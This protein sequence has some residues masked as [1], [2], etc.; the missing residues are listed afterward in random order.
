[1]KT[2]TLKRIS[3]ISVAIVIALVLSLVAVAF[4]KDAQ[5]QAQAAAGD[6]LYMAEYKGDNGTTSASLDLSAMA[7]KYGVSSD[8]IY[9]INNG[10]ELYNFLTGNVAISKKK[11]G[12]LTQDVGIAYNP[13]STIE[14]YYTVNVSSSDAIFEKGRI[15]DGNGHTINIYGGAGIS[16]SSTEVRDTDEPRLSNRNGAGRYDNFDIWYEYT[17][18][19]VA[20]N[21]GTLKDF[22]VNY[23]S[24]HTIISATWGETGTKEG[25]LGMATSN[26]ILSA[27]EGLFSAGIITGL[28]GYNGVID[29]IKVNV[30]N[31]FTVIK[32]EAGVAS[33]QKKTGQFQENSAYA[34]AIAGRIEDNSIIN[35]C[36]VDLAEGTGI[37]A[38]A[39]GKAT[40]FALTD[41]HNSMAIAGGIVGNIDAGTAKITYCS[42]SG[43]G[44]V[45]AFANRAA[46]DEKFRAYA[47]GVAG[48]CIKIANETTIS[49]CNSGTKVQQGQIKGIISS[50]RGTRFSNF[51][52]KPQE[53]MGSLFDAVGTDDEIE[54]LAIL[55]NLDAL[56]E[57]NTS[58]FAVQPK[59]TDGKLVLD[60]SGNIRNWLEINPITDGGAMTVMFD[61]DNPTYDI[62]VHIVADGH[63]EF[64]ASGAMDDFDMNSSKSR[65]QQYKMR[66]GEGGGFIWSAQFTDL[67]G[68]TSSHIDVFRDEPIYAEIYLISSKNNGKYNYEFGR[69]GSVQYVDTNGTNGNLI[70]EYH[71]VSD[72]LN[73][74]SVTMTNYDAF[75]KSVFNNPALWKITRSNKEVALSQT[76]M[77]GTYTM[78][79]ETF[80]GERAYAYYSEAERMLAWQP[81]SNY[82]FT[83][84]QGK[85]NFG[86]GTTTTDGWQD[87]VTFELAMDS[88]S[89]FDSIAFQ[90][91]G[92][93]PSGPVSADEVEY[94]REDNS[95]SASFIIKAG[96]GKNGTSY[97]FY[98]Y[99]RDTVANEDVVVAVSDSRIV[100]IDTEAPEVSEIEYYMLEDGV[101]RLLTDDDLEYIAEHWTKNQVLA[102]F[103]VIEN[104][105]SGIAVAATES[106]IQDEVLNSNGDRNVVVTIND[107]DLKE[108]K[109]VDA[110]GNET[111]VPLQINVDRVEGKLKFK[112][113]S[114]RTDGSFNYSTKN[115]MVTYTATFGKSDWRLYYSYQRNEQGGD[116]WIPCEDLLNESAVSGNDSVLTINWNMGDIYTGIG[117]D[118]KIKMINETGLYEDEVFP[119]NAEG[120]R[121]ENDAIGKYVIWL[122]LASIY[123]DTNLN[124]VFTYE[125]GEKKTVEDILLN[126]EERAEYFDKQYDGTDEYK[127]EYKFYADF[128]ELNNEDGF[129]SDDYLGVIYSPAGMSRPLIVL[130][131]NGI[132][133]VEVK[134]TSSAVG[135]TKVSFRVVLT[136]VDGYN[137]IVYFTDLSEID[138]FEDVEVEEDTY[139]ETCE[140]D[141]KINKVTITIELGEQE[142]FNSQKIY[143][144]GDE[145]PT[146]I[147]VY[148]EATDEYVPVKIDT[149]ASSTATI[150]Q[151][152][153]KGIAPNGYENIEYI[154]NSTNIEIKQRPVA[155]DLIF[156]NSDVVGNIP[157]GVTAGNSH[158][159]TG[160]YVDV[161]GETQKA[162]IEYVL[163]ERPVAT[164]SAV[165]LYTINITLPDNNYAVSG[166]TSFKFNIARGQLDIT[167]GVRVKDYTEGQLQYDLIIPEGSKDLYEESDLSIKYYEYL[168]GAT[169]NAAE[170]RVIGKPSD[171]AMTEY[172]T[173]RGFY[174]VKVEFVTKDNP[175]FFPKSDYAE[176]YLIIQRAKTEVRMEDVSLEYYFTGEKRSFNLVDAVAE[177]RSSSNKQL[178]SASTSADGIVK[179]QYKNDRGSYVDVA[180]S[181]SEGGGWFSETGRYEYRV[182]YLGNDDYD[183]SSIDVVMIINPAELKGITFNSIEA[184]Y[185]GQKHLPTASGLLGY[186]DLK[187]T[188]QYGTTR[189][190]ADGFDANEAI[191]Q[192]NFVN[193]REY[194]VTMSVSK[195]GYSTKELQ[196]K[197]TI[198]KATMEGV[199]AKVLNVVYDGKRHAIAF[200]G[201]ERDSNGNY[202]YNGESVIV[203]GGEGHYYATNVYVDPEVGP[204]YYTGEVKLTSPNFEDLVLK[205]QIMIRQA[206]LPYKEINKDLPGKVP[207]GIS[208]SEY[209]GYFVDSNGTKVECALQY[210]KYVKG[211]ESNGEIV[212][213]DE[214]G[215][216]A[217]GRYTVWLVIPNT[218]YKLD[219]YWTVDVGEI[220]S[221]EISVY[222]WV[223]IAAVVVLMVAATVTAVVV[224]K[225]RKKAGIV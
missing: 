92:A 170:G 66:T 86:S 18:Y 102:K 163:G 1:M 139:W 30:K 162:N 152:L 89:D 125:N 119:L 155:V 44:Q 6:T 11:I 220:N 20:Q 164:L 23:T 144:Y 90:R 223:A 171:D 38:G 2:K 148:V 192:L 157:T 93:F 51:N 96:T 31:A 115:V 200:E 70:K 57:T 33:G 166:Q 59:S 180:N 131:E 174:L 176:G 47:G 73:L 82:M 114:Y 87:Q 120:E 10:G 78:K 41:E 107:S 48:G 145:V 197:V 208:L 130:G 191:K 108:L 69:M 189:I 111:I 141:A 181:P 72:P 81:T 43:S 154:V 203:N 7:Q 27:K 28:N 210:R 213:P 142:A 58:S 161:N 214:N 122:R 46:K 53:S 215:V 52:N 26:R 97:T 110:R 184:V 42:L 206:D 179:V 13:P 16:N 61:I 177:V 127:K 64:K 151:Y 36:W 134:Y 173:E 25:D 71:G 15:F 54:S 149:Q 140:K 224:V 183:R 190:H 146:E 182:S 83:I 147:E 68:E 24:P 101:E 118:F 196:A 100:R 160:T 55:Y 74:P 35:Y 221:A 212:T 75:D 113:S 222:G 194:T 175:N 167:T 91:N 65:Y 199:S 80:V 201:L 5:P 17:G 129:Y 67:F 95:A 79:L 169:Y 40:S 202:T 135:N 109:Y 136:G 37:F 50:W 116:I 143:Y 207:S 205:T 104:G 216:I 49:D 165:G 63:D 121:Y 209:K 159:I 106:Y 3:L 39:K 14:G 195:D 133:P 217:D 9:A 150:N 105:K 117:D 85:L 168:E 172:P 204:S 123:L 56:A 84:L 4:L 98:A 225:K 185:D 137:Y 60:S 22:T 88:A 219:R 99:K 19:L 138:F 186:S 62:R 8:T 12:F 126:E 124:N 34:G 211:D 128:S 193:A 32:R 187:I 198:K 21:Y 188:F 77:P 158:T 94:I 218:N 76:Y 45:K 178:W 132:V 156:D 29:N 153:V 103:S 112:Y